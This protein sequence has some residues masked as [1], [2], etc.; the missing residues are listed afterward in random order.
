MRKGQGRRGARGKSDALKY[1]EL[2][3]RRWREK[4]LIQ[5]VCVCVKVQGVWSAQVKKKLINEKY[6]EVE[7]DGQ[8]ELRIQD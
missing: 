6:K 3:E 4:L 5:R 7:D 2:G 1:R 8:R